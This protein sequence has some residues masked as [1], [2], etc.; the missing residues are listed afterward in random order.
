M[1]AAQTAIARAQALL[2]PSGQGLFSVERLMPYLNIA[3]SGLRDE[4]MTQGE[5]TIAEA[6]VVIPGVAAGVKDL[7]AFVAP[8]G[9][10]ASLAAPLGIREK[11]AG[12]DDSNYF[13]VTRVGELPSRVADDFLRQFEWRGGNVY[14]IGAT[15]VLDLEVRFE[16]I[17]PA[18]KDPNNALGAVGIA[19][20]LG[21]WTAG[22][23]AT[24]MREATLGAQYIAEA[25]HQLFRWVQRQTMDSQMIRRRPRP[26]HGPNSTNV[27][28]T[29]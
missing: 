8:G 13:E 5:I 26:F 14:F 24:A 20:I 3:Y 23:M 25:R 9:V 28:T 10:L 27:G 1:E 19:N 4:G 12:T 29:L 11:V 16:Q 17:W 6:V 22:L 18:I 2:D 21:F 15:Q 7:G